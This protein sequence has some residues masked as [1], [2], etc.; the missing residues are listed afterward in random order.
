MDLLFPVPDGARWAV[1]LWVMAWV[2]LFWGSP[3][4]SPAHP[5]THLRE[6]PPSG[7]LEAWPR[8]ELLTTPS[9]CCA[10]RG[11]GPRP[12]P[13]LP[14]PP[15]PPLSP[16]QPPHLPAYPSFSP[17]IAHCSGAECC[18]DCG[19][20]GASQPGP[21]SRGRLILTSLWAP[22]APSPLP[23]LP[24][25]PSPAQAFPGLLQ[26]GGSSPPPS[27]SKVLVSLSDRSSVWAR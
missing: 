2:S 18:M 6:L 20:H 24:A 13:T 10:N 22:A 8:R 12:P 26:A 15:P 7:V 25:A 21:C 3:E 16:P 4:L 14:R 1:S 9:L 11:P 17:S 5:S 27:S 23:A 19:F